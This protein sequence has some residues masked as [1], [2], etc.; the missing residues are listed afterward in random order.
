MAAFFGLI[1]YA[2]VAI[3]IVGKVPDRIEAFGPLL[4]ALISHAAIGT[5]W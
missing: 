1:V 2:E 3:C 5:E 4:Q